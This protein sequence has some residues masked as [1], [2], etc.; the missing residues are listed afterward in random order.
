MAI[1]N[2]TL[3]ALI[4]RATTIWPNNMTQE[5]FIPQIQVLEAIRA[6]QTARL[7]PV[8]LPDNPDVKAVWLNNCDLTVDACVDDVCTFSGESASSFVQTLSI[9]Q[10]AQ[11]EVSEPYDA[12]RENEFQMADA[13]SVNLNKVMK[14]QAEYVA[15][16]AVGVINTSAGVNEHTNQG[17]WVVN[18]TTTEVPFADFD[19][20][21]IYGKL[22]RSAV[23]NR[24]SNPF[25]LSGENLDQIQYMALTGQ[26]NADGKG[27][28]ARANAL[29]AYFDLFN[30]DSVNTVGGE[31]SYLTY[32]INRGALAFASKG[33]FP[34]VDD[35]T[36]PRGA[37]AFT[38]GK[39]RFSIANRF[40]PN[41]IHDVEMFD[42]CDTGV[43][44]LHMRI[45][46]RYKV[47]VNPTGCTATRTGIL[48]FKNMLGI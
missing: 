37:Q 28:A 47:F 15:R 30:V 17:Q 11:T 8:G 27:D 48:R 21:S 41:L 32:M 36:N 18:G 16:Y 39:L 5:D 25:I 35:P 38:Y 14:A 45:K 34:R 1:T 9:D 22:R 42:A 4:Q 10:C 44:K 6:E 7:E 13:M 3:P 12:W 29:R 40:F 20:T 19:N 46:A 24:L 31:T 2:S 26:M 33:Y 43:E 23:I